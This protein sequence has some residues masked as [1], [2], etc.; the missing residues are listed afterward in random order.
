MPRA[1][2]ILT[3][4]LLLPACASTPTPY[5]PTFSIT[6]ASVNKSIDEA[7]AAPTDKELRNKAVLDMKAYHDQEFAKSAYAKVTA[8]NSKPTVFRNLIGAAGTTAGL[9]VDEDDK[10]ATIQIGSD[11]ATV[12]MGLF[13]I[14]SSVDNSID[15]MQSRRSAVWIEVQFKLSLDTT[16]YPLTS[17]IADMQRYENAGL[18]R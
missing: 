10:K 6:D 3:I 15:G 1:L 5:T 4:T 14:G 12:V 2:C 16:K 11:F 18:S 17:A 9:L 8:K 13:G 7:R